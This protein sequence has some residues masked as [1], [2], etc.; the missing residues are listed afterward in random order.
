MI[1]IFLFSLVY[2]L[3]ICADA[4]QPESAYQSSCC[5]QPTF[6]AILHQRGMNRVEKD[7]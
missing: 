7:G 5:I 1:Y 4:V 6:P 2:F 3:I